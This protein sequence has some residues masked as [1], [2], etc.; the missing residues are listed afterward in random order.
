MATKT[1]RR[2]T[3]RKPTGKSVSP[4]MIALKTM[5]AKEIAKCMD[6][7][8]GM[9]QSEA[10]ALTGEAASQLSL[11][12]NG[13][14]KGFSSERLEL[15]LSQFGRNITVVVSK[16]ESKRGKIAGIVK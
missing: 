4:Q 9:T 13:K 15:I 14:L 1:P 3:T 7:G 12:Y 6:A 16:S 2:K 10:A 11:I 5:L 8:E